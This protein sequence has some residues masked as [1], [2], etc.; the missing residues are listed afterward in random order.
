[1]DELQGNQES[2]LVKHIEKYESIPYIITS[3]TGQNKLASEVENFYDLRTW[4]EFHYLPLGFSRW[5]REYKLGPE[6]PG[7]LGSIP[8]DLIDIV[9]PFSKVKLDQG[10]LEYGQVRSDYF[11]AK[12]E[13]NYSASRFILGTLLGT[14]GSV[15]STYL[16]T[17]TGTLDGISI[18]K[19]VGIFEAGFLGGL[20]WALSKPS[21]SD[22]SLYQFLNLHEGA[23]QVDEFIQSNYLPYFVGRKA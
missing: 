21:K 20:F 12:S 3:L 15:L 10:K 6:E 4:E 1:M 18:I 14:A 11:T 8:K 19:A 23:I 7:K 5:V 16:D 17:K 22:D 13:G 2:S 9:G